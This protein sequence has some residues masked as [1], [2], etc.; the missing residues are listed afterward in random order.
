MPGKPKDLDSL[1]AEASQAN[2]N[3]R[4]C[5]LGNAKINADETL[6]SFIGKLE[7]APDAFVGTRI[8]DILKREWGIIIGAHSIRRHL[9][10]DC[11]CQRT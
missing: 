11:S 3:R 7:T 4:G 8:S 5:S 10:G 6:L 9:R 1:L 2:Y